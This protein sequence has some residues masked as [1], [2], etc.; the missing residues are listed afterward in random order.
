MRNAVFFLVVTVASSTAAFAQARFG[1]GVKDH[2]DPPGALVTATY[3][4]YPCL[5]IYSAEDDQYYHLAPYLHVVTE[6]NGVRIGTGKECTKAVF[7]SPNRMKFRI[8]NRHSGS[9]RYYEV[10]LLGEPT[11]ELNLGRSL[12]WR[13][14]EAHSKFK[15]VV[16][17][18]EEDKWR[19][20]PGYS[21]V[22]GT[23]LRDVRWSPG[24]AH[25]DHHIY[26]GSEAGKWKPKPGY[27]WVSKAEKDFRVQWTPGEHHPNHHILA[28]S[29]AGVWTPM[30]GHAWV[31]KSTEDL[32]VRWASGKRHPKYQILASKEHGQ[33]HPMDGYEWVTSRN[34][35]FRVQ[36]ERSSSSSSSSNNHARVN[37]GAEDF[38]IDAQ[39]L[40]QIDRGHF[41]S[42]YSTNSSHAPVQSGR[43]Y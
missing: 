18:P 21:W 1:I 11:G 7:A 14:G 28:A 41:N 17:A 22:E 16:A 8:H 12:D 30:P 6:I 36:R 39:F 37:S 29:E 23:G 31:S 3:Q 26:A 15:H 20:A 32:R 13:P 33:W 24:E 42:N 19:P 5:N 27:N 2:H 9:H 40:R 34:G 10:D 35:D 4:G 38:G 43:G 25:P